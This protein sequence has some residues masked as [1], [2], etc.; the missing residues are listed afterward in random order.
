MRRIV[1]SLLA[2]ALVL[3]ACS[4]DDDTDSSS[5]TALTE[6]SGGT[7]PSTI[8][9]ACLGG[10]VWYHQAIEHD[11]FDHDLQLTSMATVDEGDD[12]EPISSSPRGSS[13]VSSA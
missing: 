9:R 11:L 6:S 5:S 2:T 12:D 13:V 7:S 8:A 4:G 3:A 10:L 1:I